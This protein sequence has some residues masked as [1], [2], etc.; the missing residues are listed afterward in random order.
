[1]A[2]WKM[3]PKAKVYEAMGA[4][5]DERVTITGHTTA[6]VQSSSCDKTYDVKQSDDISE[7]T[8]NDNASYWQGYIG[9]PIIAVLMQI[10]KLSFNRQLAKLLTGVP[11]KSINEQF[12]RDYDKAINHI[13]DGI[14][15]NGGDRTE[16][17]QEVDKIY[18][19]FGK[20]GLQRPK[21]RSRPPK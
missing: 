11:W 20:F 3:P 9:Y 14:E 19:Q 21:R 15:T 1:M 12:K 5:A 8:S 13:L 4:V 10:G 2:T 17:I 7:I 6:E 16:I 18:K